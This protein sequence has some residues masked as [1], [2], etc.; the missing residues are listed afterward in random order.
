MEKK[1]LSGLTLIELLASVAIIAILVLLVINTFIGQIAKGNDAKRKAD[2]DRIKVA[3]EEYEKDHNCYPPA[4][5]VVC[6]NGGAGLKPY[7]NLIPCDPVTH[8]SYA[9]EPGPGAC[10]GWF[11]AYAKLQNTADKS[12]IPSIGPGQ[13]Y[14]YYV[15]SPNAPALATGY[16]SGSDTGYWGCIKGYCVPLKLTS[17]GNPVCGPSYQT[18]NCPNSD[19][20]SSAYECK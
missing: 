18:S 2:L 19:S 9:Y 3:T 4:N 20:C 11:R 8:Q 7:L 14:N 12:I 15:F 5:L 10:G 1:Y 6:E 16:E 13:L 17:P